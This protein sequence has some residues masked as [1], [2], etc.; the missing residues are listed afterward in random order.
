MMY[1]MGIICLG[2]VIFGWKSGY[3]SNF[4]PILDIQEPLTD[5]HKVEAKKILKKKSKM[6]DSKKNEF[7]KMVNFQK[8]QGLVLGLMGFIDAKDIDDAQPIWL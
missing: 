2:W 1:T 3:L 6:T 5:F 8:N 7:F 4:C